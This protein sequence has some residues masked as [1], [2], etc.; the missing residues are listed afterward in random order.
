M[1]QITSDQLREYQRVTD[2]ERQ[3]GPATEWTDEVLTYCAYGENVAGGRLPWPCMDNKFRLQEGSTTVLCGQS[4]AGKSMLAGQIVLHQLEQKIPA[5]VVSLEMKC[6]HSIARMVRQR[7][8]IAQPTTD[9]VMN[10][11]RWSKDKLWFYRQ[12]GSINFNTLLAVIRYSVAN[13]GVKFIVVDSLMTMGDI[14]SDD[15]Q[16]QKRLMLALSIAARDLGA[17]IMLITH[18]RKNT[19]VDQRIDKYS[20]AG[21]ADLTNLACNVVLLQRTSTSQRAN[22]ATA[23]DARFEVCK[24]RHFDT[25]EMTLDLWFDIASMN[26]HTQWDSPR[27]VGE[28]ENTI[29]ESKGSPSAAMGEITVID[30]SKGTRSRHRI[31][32]NGGAGRGSDA[33]ASG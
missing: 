30:S 2:V 28:D 9:D 5:L 27:K 33:V 26:Y 16:G 8:L 24:A 15:Y 31:K 32:V 10:F 4:G 23:P 20:V 12:Q 14:P 17:H 29:S 22:N 18:A 13:F 11:T 19:S 7:S 6:A 3:V 25:A 21:T 1:P